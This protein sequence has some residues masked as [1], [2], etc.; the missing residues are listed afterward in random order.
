M[1]QYSKSLSSRLRNG[2]SYKPFHKVTPNDLFCAAARNSKQDDL[3]DFFDYFKNKEHYSNGTYYAIVDKVCDSKHFVSA[4]LFGHRIWYLRIGR[5]DRE[6]IHNWSTL[7]TIKNEIVGAEYEAVELYPAQSRL[8]NNENVYHLWILAPG[9]T[10][11]KPP[12]FSIG[13]KWEGGTKHLIRKTQ[14]EKMSLRARKEVSE[15]KT[16]VLVPEEV[17]AAAE[18]EFPEI[19]GMIAAYHYVNAHPEIGSSLETW[20][21]YDQ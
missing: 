14:F 15:N 9:E 10:E 6:P 2:Y 21:S 4:D 17:I 3:I 11:T 18:Q 13:Y 8:M 19:P 20:N 16:V 5:I 1:G 12:R 7:Q